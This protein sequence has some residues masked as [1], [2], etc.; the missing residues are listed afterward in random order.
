M[1]EAIFASFFHAISTDEDPHHT[2]CPE[3]ATGWCFYQRA[4]AKGAEPGSHR[5]KVHTPLSLEVASHV[6]DLYLDLSHRDLLNWCLRVETQ[7][8]N[9]CI[10]SKVWLKCPKTG[11]V[12]LMRVVAAVCAAF[13]EFNEGIGVM[14]EQTFNLID[15]PTGKSPTPCRILSASCMSNLT[16]FG[17]FT[18]KIFF[19]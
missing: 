15:I 4:L 12:G 18:A 17:A 11:F 3:G 5:D 2:Y 7:N 1:R 6:K 10:H 16:A 19:P 14:I 13:A 9:E 8:K